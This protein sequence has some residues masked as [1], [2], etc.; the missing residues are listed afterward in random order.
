MKL[1]RHVKRSAL[2]LS[3]PVHVA[4]ALAS[5]ASVALTWI[6]CSPSPPSPPTWVSAN[7]TATEGA[8]ISS[9]D[10]TLYVPPHALAQD[11]TLRIR[12]LS[13]NHVE[14][15]PELTFAAPVWMYVG[16]AAARALRRTDIDG[17]TLVPSSAAPGGLAAMIGGQSDWGTDNAPVACG[18]GIHDC[19]VQSFDIAGVPDCIAILGTA[20]DEWLVESEVATMDSQDPYVRF[21]K[22]V[23]ICIYPAEIDPQIRV[24]QGSSPTTWVVSVPLHVPRIASFIY[25]PSQRSCAAVNLCSTDERD[26]CFSQLLDH[27]LGHARINA[28]LDFTWSNEVTVNHVKAGTPENV[29]KVN[30]Y[31]EKCRAWYFASSAIRSLHEAYHATAPPVTRGMSPACVDCCRTESYGSNTPDHYWR[32]GVNVECPPSEPFMRSCDD[33]DPYGAALVCCL[34]Q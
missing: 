15:S 25:M 28:S 26:R 8:M 30:A 29:I 17:T 6:A 13:T 12:E 32:C 1:H 2:D 16:D 20:V 7:V 27:E 9:G 22:T 33:S 21:G 14:L 31:M 23:P 10:A 4:V 18:E 19:F 11:T 34:S 3:K 5:V 24:T